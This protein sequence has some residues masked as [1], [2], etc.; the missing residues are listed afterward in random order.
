M[1]TRVLVMP[2]RRIVV[3]LLAALCLFVVMT[4][5]SMSASSTGS[6]PAA[7]A[8]R[9]SKATPSADAV[10]SAP[11]RS[12]PQTGSPTS[13]ALATL[14][15][16]DDP[17][18]YARAVTEALFGVAPSQVTRSAFLRFWVG[19]LPNVVYSDA[20][21]KGLRLSRQSADAIDSLTTWWVPSQAVWDSE[22]AQELRN[23]FLITSVAVPDYWANAVADGQFRD[24]GLRMERVM[25]VLTQTYGTDSQHRERSSRSVV[26]DVGLLCGPTQPEG[27][28]LLAPQQPD[29]AGS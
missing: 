23:R 26:I 1:R 4:R 20:A 7:P 14:V 19:E 11:S 12:M 6:G 25:G 18:T 16:T 21:A 3:G 24:P 29:S 10:S 9:S 22:A 5:H 27:C 13:S 17:D 2:R 8:S 28:R 15:R